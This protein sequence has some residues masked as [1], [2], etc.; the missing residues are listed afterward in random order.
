MNE[1]KVSVR[2]QGRGDAGAK[3]LE[4]FINELTAEIKERRGTEADAVAKV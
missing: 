1:G 4:E 2:R 3:N